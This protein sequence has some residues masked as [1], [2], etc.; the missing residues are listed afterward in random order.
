M[1]NVTSEKRES[2]LSGRIWQ[3][4][5]GLTVL[6]LA[7]SLAVWYM[8]RS[9]EVS[10][11]GTAVEYHADDVDHAAD[12]E[13]VIWGTY[14]WDRTGKRTFEGN[15]WIDGLDMAPGTRVR[16]TS[17]PGGDQF[18]DVSGQPVITPVCGILQSPDGQG[19]VALLWDEYAAEFG[20][21]SAV[22][23]EGRCFICIGTLSRQDAAVLADTLKQQIT[24]I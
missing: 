19:A 11:S 13:A 5:A 9:E 18:Y 1:K 7:A 6:C 4:L 21:V 8:P 15:F 14:T 12:H 23:E 16:L 20:S 17:E 10:W 22:L 2:P 24:G 3:W